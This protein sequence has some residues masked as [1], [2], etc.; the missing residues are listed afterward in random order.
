MSEVSRRQTPL[1]STNYPID[2]HGPAQRRNTLIRPITSWWGK[3]SGL[4]LT[5]KGQGA[6]I[7]SDHDLVMITFKV[8]RKKMRNPN[9]P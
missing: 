3:D 2:G 7:G 1:V 5:S 8:R 6:Y 4:E 9:Q